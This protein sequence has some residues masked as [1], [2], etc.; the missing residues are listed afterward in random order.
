MIY[1]TPQEEQLEEEQLP[2]ADVPAD[3]T[4]VS[5]EGPEDFEINPHADINRDRSW[6]LQE[7]HSGVEPPITRVSKFSLQLLHLYS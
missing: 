3:L 2:Q 6:L 5:P 4:V 7:G 1:P